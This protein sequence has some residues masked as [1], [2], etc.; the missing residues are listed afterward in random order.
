MLPW[1]QFPWIQ[2]LGTTVA[3]QIDGPF[4]Q[5]LLVV[6]PKVKQIA[7]RD[8]DEKGNLLLTLLLGLCQLANPRAFF[9]IYEQTRSRV[10][11]GK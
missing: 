7:T 1:I 2:R 8:Q 9:C 5:A 3:F 6:H 10:E 4:L 11:T